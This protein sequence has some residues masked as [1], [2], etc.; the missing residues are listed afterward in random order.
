MDAAA[1]VLKVPSKEDQEK[2]QTL[3]LLM[4]GHILELTQAIN[5]GTATAQ[6]KEVEE[7]QETLADFLKILSTSYKVDVY[8]PPRPLTEK[9]Y[10]GPLGCEF[11]GKKRIEGSNACTDK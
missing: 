3:P 9:D 5:E 11:W 7:I 1:K 2:L 4:K 10:L 6:S 8:R